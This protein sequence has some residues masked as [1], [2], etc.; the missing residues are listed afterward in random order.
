MNPLHK[1]YR[2][3]PER[4]KGQNWRYLIRILVRQFCNETRL[5]TRNGG[6][7][8]DALSSYI[9]L[10]LNKKMTLLR[11]EPQQT[12]WLPPSSIRNPPANF[13]KIIRKSP[14]EK[15]RISI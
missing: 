15:Y 2:R 4:V 14:V 9:R 10:I 6:G 13:G 3:A 5:E 11:I 7:W 8:P 12:E 1:A